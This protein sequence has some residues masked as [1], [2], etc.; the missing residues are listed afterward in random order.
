MGPRMTSL[1]LGL[2]G[3]FTATLAAS[4][5][6]GVPTDPKE[7]ENAVGQPATLEVKPDTITI[8]G[9]RSVQ[10]LVVTGRYAD[11]TVRDLTAFAAFTTPDVGVL[12]AAGGFVR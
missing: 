2:A 12:D 7:R 1:R 3:L 10:Q 8:D 9:P 4:A 11:G 6:A 5:S